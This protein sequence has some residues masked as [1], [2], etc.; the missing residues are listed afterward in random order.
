MLSRRNTT[1]LPLGQR[2]LAAALAGVMVWLAV[3]AASPTWHAWAHGGT[4]EHGC[5][6]SADSAHGPTPADPNADHSCAVT[7]YAQ[8]LTLAMAATPAAAPLPVEWGRCGLPG[9]QAL[10]EWRYR[11]QPK[12]GPPLG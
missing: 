9:R 8:G 2:F 3:L 7:L 1:S 11:F 10:S 12:R 5:T 6:G 4:T